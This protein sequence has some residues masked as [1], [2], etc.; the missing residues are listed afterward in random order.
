MRL[1]DLKSKKYKS[2]IGG[3]SHEPDEENPVIG[4]RG[5]GRYADPAF[6]DCFALG[7]KARKR[8][9]EDMGMTNVELMT[10]FVRTLD[11]AADVRDI[12]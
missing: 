5:C 9:R 7:L 6:V 4:S 2:I 11:V 8:V 3:D 1:S 10:P 12:L